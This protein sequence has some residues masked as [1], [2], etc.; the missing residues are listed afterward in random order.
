MVPSL[1]VRVTGRRALLTCLDLFHPLPVGGECNCCC[2]RTAKSKRP[3]SDA[4]PT[5]P[6]PQPV[7]SSASSLN[8]SRHSS[9][10]N[11]VDSF[12]SSVQM[13]SNS[14]PAPLRNFQPTPAASSLTS[15]TSSPSSS[16]P[17]P[18][19]TTPLS[20]VAQSSRRN[21]SIP[22]YPYHTSASV[23]KTTLYSPYGKKG[24]DSRSSSR[25]AP[26]SL[27]SPKDILASTAN[28]NLRELVGNYIKAKE[29]KARGESLPSFDKLLTGEGDSQIGKELGLKEN[30]IVM[31]G[32]S[33]LSVDLSSKTTSL[34]LPVSSRMHVW[35]QLQLPE[36]RR[37]WQRTDG[38]RRGR[39][40]S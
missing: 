28:R 19:S 9:L 5:R 15:S 33:N 22:N 36:L 21:G 2:P 14:L 4:N 18:A 27:P 25:G 34:T 39:G 10:E 11:L 37:A 16:M 7:P 6:G 24:S 8:D 31:S 38:R 20:V 3:P 29:K 32:K 35:R 40:S 30:L 17:P 23:H 12:S 26:T 13:H 1:I